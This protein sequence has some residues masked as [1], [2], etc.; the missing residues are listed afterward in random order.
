M[1]V[2]ARWAP[3]CRRTD[4]QPDRRCTDRRASALDAG[5]ARRRARPVGR[6]AARVAHGGR[7]PSAPQVL[8]RIADTLEAHRDELAALITLEMGKTIAEARAEVDKSAGACRYYAEHGEAHLAQLAVET[9]WA[10]SYVQFPPLGVVLAVMPWNY[11]VWQVLR[12]A[13][14]IWAAGNTVVLKH[15]SNVTG[16]ALRLAEILADV[17]EDGAL[18]ETVVTGPRGRRA[19][20]RRPADRGRHAHRAPRPPGS[21]SRPPAPAT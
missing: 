15:A 21:P 7:P 13:A 6:D 2:R 8:I 9:E 1:T 14:P 4:H 19:P 20:D 5:G 16:S 3:R 10:E 18:L 11:P 12:A 17:A